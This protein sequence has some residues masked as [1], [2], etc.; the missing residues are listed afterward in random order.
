MSGVGT[1]IARAGAWNQRIQRYAMPTGRREREWMYS[2]NCVWYAVVNGRRVRTQCRRA[3]RP[4]G[5][6]VARCTACGAKSS[7]RR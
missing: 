1:I 6:S 5:P 3:A 2:G 7:M 4:S